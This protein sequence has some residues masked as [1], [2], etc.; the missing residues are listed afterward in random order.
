MLLNLLLPGLDISEVTFLEKEQHGFAFNQKKCIFDVYCETARKERIVVEMQY[1]SEDD[2][3]DRT[4][5]YATYRLS[6]LCRRRFRS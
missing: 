6:L 5:F 4:L 2:Y 3:L 1:R